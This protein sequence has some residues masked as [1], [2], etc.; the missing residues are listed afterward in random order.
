[1]VVTTLPRSQGKY[2][3][4]F[5]TKRR[6]EDNLTPLGL[7][8]PAEGTFSITIEP[9]NDLQ[10]FCEFSPNH[11][12]YCRQRGNHAILRVVHFFRFQRLRA[13]R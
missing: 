7:A 4:L 5:V 9:T 13:G 2:P 10:A 12:H 1:M 8:Q 3:L 11:N 6:K